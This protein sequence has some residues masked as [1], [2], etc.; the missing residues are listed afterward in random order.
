M[1]LDIAS[2]NDGAMGEDGVYL[3]PF[4]VSGQPAMTL[5][6]AESAAGLPI[7][8]QLVGRPADESTLFRLAGQ[9]ERARPWAQRRPKIH[10]SRC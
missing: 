7:G 9:L 6:L 1:S 4:N 2:Y 3:A 5:P 8:V 10:A